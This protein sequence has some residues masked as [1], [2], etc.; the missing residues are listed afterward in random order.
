MPTKKQNE[1]WEEKRAA[2]AVYKSNKGDCNV[3]MKE[4]ALGTW[5]VAQRVAFNNGT[6]DRAR[7]DALEEMGFEWDPRAA[8]WER[9]RAELAVYKSNEGD[10]NVPW[11]EGAL[12]TWVVAQR[13][14]FNNGTL[15]RARQDALEEMG[16]EWDPRAAACSGR[17]TRNRFFKYGKPPGM[18]QSLSFEVDVRD[19]CL[20]GP[21]GE[22]SAAV[23]GRP[24]KGLGQAVFQFYNFFTGEVLSPLQL[25][26]GGRWMMDEVLILVEAGETGIAM[27]T[28]N[29]AVF[30]LDS[31]APAS[32]L[33]V[34]RRI[35][36][37]AEEAEARIDG[38]KSA[39]VMLRVFEA[40]FVQRQREGGVGSDAGR[41]LELSYY[42]TQGSC[43]QD[44]PAN[45]AD[46]AG[47]L[48]LAVEGG[49]MQA[50]PLSFMK[51]GVIVG[52]AMRNT[53]GIGFLGSP[54]M[55]S[56]PYRSDG[57]EFG[58]SHQA[59]G[60]VPSPTVPSAHFVETLTLIVRFDDADVVPGLRILPVP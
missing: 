55:L 34:L 23:D 49:G 48:V 37:K 20:A 36:A 31:R 11:N 14:A 10:C 7:Q 22:G 53:G 18:P 58:L 38:A 32:S 33:E 45:L 30:T 39:V 50:P 12:G 25:Q 44:D 26:A 42:K 56:A 3:P 5:V 9:S 6:L 40:M 13:V 28:R 41:Y 15:D 51:N 21:G 24:V 8:A 16:F 35:L 29:G 4:G 57:N 43:H 2:L 47:A 60:K 1:K 59:T 27:R 17:A 19:L 52:E 46:I 54:M